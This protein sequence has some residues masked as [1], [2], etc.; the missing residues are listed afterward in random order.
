MR[1]LPSLVLVLAAPGC[2]GDRAQSPAPPDATVV[3]PAPSADPAPV[4]PRAEGASPGAAAAGPFAGK[5]GHP[6]TPAPAITGGPPGTSRSSIEGCL[7]AA[8]EAEARRLPPPAPPTRSGAGGG[9]EISPVEGG[10]LVTHALSHAC[11]L[12]GA[13]STSIESD[14]VT[15]TERLRGDPC[16]CM[17]GSTLRTAV[18]LEPGRYRLALVVEHGETHGGGRIERILERTVEVRAR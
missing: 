2:A 7:V 5:L 13:V 18:R 17:C 15:V 11:C 4:P 9:V 1:L 6:V 10:L 3:R 8:G 12:S 16:R 14:L